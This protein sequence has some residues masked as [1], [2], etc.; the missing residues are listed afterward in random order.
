MLV[1]PL[2]NSALLAPTR[3]ADVEG[4][5]DKVI[6]GKVCGV[7]LDVKGL[8]RLACCV[9]GA[10]AAHLHGSRGAAGLQSE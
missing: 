10:Q 6:S 1:R 7:R 8:V 2:G 4:F 9:S 5:C 3:C